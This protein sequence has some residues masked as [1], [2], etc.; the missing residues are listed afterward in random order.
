MGPLP[1]SLFLWYALD[2]TLAAET[3]LVIA[4]FIPFALFAQHLVSGMII[5]VG[6]GR[7][8]GE[9]TRA[10]A[11]RTV[12][13]GFDTHPRRPP[14]LSLVIGGARA[15]AALLDVPRRFRAVRE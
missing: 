1:A 10:H 14:V 15:P 8:G 9:G 5:G 2:V 12:S 3:H 7:R 13:E 4:L 11:P 6:G